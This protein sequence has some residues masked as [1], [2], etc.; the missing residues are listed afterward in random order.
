MP[1]FHTSCYTV[2]MFT[3]ILPVHRAIG[4]HKV[5]TAAT[6]AKSVPLERIK[7][8]IVLVP[9]NLRAAMCTDRNLPT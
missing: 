6:E 5:D 4:Q 7:R 3:S 1:S 8:N 2:R 9:V